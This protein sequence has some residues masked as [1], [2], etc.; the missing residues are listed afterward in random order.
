MDY[1]AE[2]ERLYS[3]SNG[4]TIGELK[5]FSYDAMLLYEAL[6]RSTDDY[7]YVSNMKTEVFCYSPLL[8]K[9][10]GFPSEI[11]Y[12][13][14]PYWKK[15]VHPDDWE[16][17]YQSNM[18]I[19]DEKTNYHS[20][21]F[22]ALQVNGEYQW[23]RCRGYLM[24]DK[25]NRP[26]FFA[27]FMS[28]LDRQNKIDPVTSL[29]SIHEFARNFDD[30][31]R[32]NYNEPVTMMVVGL[33]NF[34]KLNE[35]YNWDFGSL[36]LKRC[37]S[38]I[39]EIIP[40]TASVYRLDG[41]KFGV[42]LLRADAPYAGQIFESIKTRFS[43]ITV[44]GQTSVRVTCSGGSAAYPKD[45][46]SYLDMV[47]YCDYALQNAKDKGKNCFTVFHEGILNNKSRALELLS[48]L[49]ESISSQ[50][51]GFSL[52]FQ[53]QVNAETGAVKGVEALLRWKC[54]K[55]GNV[56]PIEFIPVLEDNRLINEVGKWVLIHSM[57][58]LKEFL[59]YDESFT[60]SVNVS[61]LQL[62]DIFYIQDLINI[63]KDCRINPQNIII[64]LTES[65][66]VNS[67]QKLQEIFDK[68]R[69]FG[70]RVA[71]DD[72]GTGYSSLELLK[73]ATFD[74]VKVDRGFVKG[75]L[76]SKF[77]VSFIECMIK[78]CHDVGIAVCIEGVETQEEY[79]LLKSMKPEYIQGYYFGR[80]Q[81]S[82]EIMKHYLTV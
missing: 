80:P 26:D 15:I 21:E 31:I 9:T 20:V 72:F 78:L 51:E 70:I 54:E 27:G 47:K 74:I 4:M 53:P 17:F 3:K 33:D 14:L 56:S 82:E 43:K 5:D 19:G 69:S 48:G 73:N 55:L 23:L 68:L 50:F 58:V 79:K 65:Y 42:L 71:M 46:N 18:E 2:T 77:D 35:L 76:S 1:K 66:L 61:Y 24:R 16:R 29:L 67:T 13:P 11:M 60:I 75:I 34:K 57:K 12:R 38:I 32:N 25:D 6:M 37:G 39:Q 41:D 8:V 22:R 81:S 7:I 49:Q 44:S 52:M 30:F 45:A 62:L 36:V 40:E 64:E 10:F 59:Q 28:K 63:I